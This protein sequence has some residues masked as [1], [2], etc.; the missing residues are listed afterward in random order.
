[1]PGEHEGAAMTTSSQPNAKLLLSM[2]ILLGAVFALGSQSLASAQTFQVLYNFTGG[3]DGTG[4]PDGVTLDRA[5]N[6]Y[7]TASAG[8]NQV[9]GCSNGWGQTGCG[10]VFELAHSGS[11]WIM[12]PLYDF[13]GGADY[14]NPDEGVV[15]GLDGALYGTSSATVFRLQPPPTFCASVNCS[16]QETLLHQFTGQP[17]ASSPDSR[18]VFDTAGN[19]Y[20]VTFFGGAENE[21]A[22]YEVTPSSGSWTESV[23]YSF[24][25]DAG[26]GVGTYLP[27]GPLVLDQ[28]GN[29]YGTAYCDEIRGCFST[30]WQLQHSES[31]WLLNNIFNFGG[32]QGYELDGVISDA[33]GNLY[34]LSDGN[35]QT[36]G[37]ENAYELSPSNGNWTFTQLYDLGEEGNLSGPAMDSAGNLYGSNIISGYGTIFKLT[38]SGNS[39]TYSV[40]HTFNSNDGEFPVGT[41][42]VDSSGNLYG[43]TVKGGMFGYG[44]IW[45]ITP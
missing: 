6:L 2:V 7:G 19:M 25:P 24:N 35:Q 13:Q 41:L 12:K 37:S 10:A 16:W 22:A 44:V 32:L 4:P 8:G 1:M 23:I 28:S 31:G 14:G 29:L 39:Y 42:T 45:E 11:S 27:N 15:F 38:R 30:V 26:L 17:D 33:S 36:N 18:L 3:R 9:S 40:L 20:G 34:G 5:G 21:G 43:T